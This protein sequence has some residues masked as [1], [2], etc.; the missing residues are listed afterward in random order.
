MKSTLFL[1][2]S[3][4]ASAFA[5]A[6][7]ST[8]EAATQFG[9]VAY[10][11][12]SS[13]LFSTLASN[14]T[15]AGLLAA[16]RVFDSAGDRV[17]FNRLVQIADT[18]LF[19]L[20]S[21]RAAF[22]ETAKRF[23][24]AD[25]CRFVRC[26]PASAW[27]QAPSG[28]LRFENELVHRLRGDDA[29]AD[30]ARGVLRRIAET[31][32]HWFARLAP[33]IGLSGGDVFATCVSNMAVAVS[34]EE[35]ELAR[36]WRMRALASMGF[37][38]KHDEHVASFLSLLD[39]TNPD[40]F[41]CF[42]DVSRQTGRPGDAAD[43]LVAWIRAEKPV[44][45]V[46][47]NRIQNFCSCLIPEDELVELVRECRRTT[48]ISSLLDAGRAQEAQAWAESFY[49]PGAKPGEHVTAPWSL[50]GQ[51]QAASGA[52]FFKD[53]ADGLSNGGETNR[54]SV[55][56]RHEYYLGRGETETAERILRD[57]IRDCT[58]SADRLP[59]RLSLSSRL[60]DFLDRNH[61]TAEA[62]EVLRDAYEAGFADLD[63]VEYGQRNATANAH[64]A[65]FYSLACRLRAGGRREE[66]DRLFRREIIAG[67]P[68]YFYYYLA[69]SLSSG[70]RLDADDPVI[71][72]LLEQERKPTSYFAILRPNGF[73]V[74]GHTLRLCLAKDEQFDSC[75]DE[76]VADSVRFCKRPF[77][78]LLS[79]LGEMEHHTPVSRA[80][81]IAARLFDDF[82]DSADID[83]CWRFWTAGASLRKYESLKQELERA[84]DGRRLS[85]E[86][87]RDGLRILRGKAPNETERTW[88]E[89]E[90][91]KFF[92]P[93]QNDN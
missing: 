68:G 55:L 42:V 74:W 67:R 19:L 60:A 82:G 46:E 7:D 80:P 50:L 52:H 23:G 9:R 35:P 33:A 90:L 27:K 20:P 11:E 17:S 36:I 65:I 5:N 26:V 30:E 93:P 43:A 3:V 21:V 75:L 22:E 83:E 71:R 78:G 85:A 16:E 81:I 84:W 88:C 64:A 40:D 66:W 29:A 73:P 51:M 89:A 28:I 72:S 54:P 24:C 59:E 57:G 18:N 70:C 44:S 63:G 47:R 31:D 34:S 49:G 32:P 76:A 48:L 37:E 4:C 41:W 86:R 8:V 45:D 38:R 62:E 13:K 58:A 87:R 39:R 61:R 79:V 56:E 53:R 91:S 2:F 6:T 69:W 77:D 15:E 1:L 92:P 25:W 12:M 14:Q 10:A